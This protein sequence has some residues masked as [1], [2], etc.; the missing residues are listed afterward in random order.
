MAFWASARCLRGR[1]PRKQLGNDL[2][3]GKIPASKMGCFEGRAG[4][5][6][7][8]GPEGYTSG[9]G[10]DLTAVAEVIMGYDGAQPSIAF[11]SGR[12]RCRLKAAGMTIALLR[13]MHS[14][15]GF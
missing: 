13:R 14:S 15:V 12:I 10:A 9:R 5:D 2:D 1:R 4:P 8:R 6:G 7:V 3:A 11:A